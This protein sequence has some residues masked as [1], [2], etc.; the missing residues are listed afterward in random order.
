MF[1][2]SA[3]ARSPITDWCVRG[4]IG[5]AFV[6]FGL[7]KFSLHSM[8]PKFFEDVGAGQ[9]FRYFTGIV[10][11]LGGILTA[12]PATSQIG[13]A[14]LALTMAGATAIWVYPMGHPGNTVVTGAFCCGL[15]ALWWTRRSRS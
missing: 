4:G 1:E 6:I 5:L 10:E 2:T 9:W 11:I 13:V 8:W 3:E 14:L 12:I 15:S 7:D